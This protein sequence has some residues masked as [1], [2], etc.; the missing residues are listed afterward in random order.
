MLILQCLNVLEIV[1][2][3]QCLNILELACGFKLYRYVSYIAMM[4]TTEP[5]LMNE[6]SWDKMPFD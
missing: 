3:L 5:Y 4:Q 1:L 6:V 2:V